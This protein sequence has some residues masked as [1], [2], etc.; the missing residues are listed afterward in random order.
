MIKQHYGH[1]IKLEYRKLPIIYNYTNNMYE[2][3]VFF[4]TNILY[5]IVLYIPFITFNCFF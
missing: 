5:F 2:I 3:C 1:T 4:Y